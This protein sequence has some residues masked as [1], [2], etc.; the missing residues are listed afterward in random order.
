MRTSNTTLR[1]V[2]LILLACLLS[3][4]D[5]GLFGTGDGQI[6]VEADNSNIGVGN[7]VVATPTVDGSSAVTPQ[8][9]ENLQIATTITAPLINIINVSDQAV[10]ARLDTNN[11]TLLTASIAPTTFS[12]V[13]QLQLGENNLVLINPD[14]SEE[15]LNIRPLTVGASSLT[16][17]IV[18]NTPTQDLNGVLLSSMSISLTPTV[19]QLRIVQADLLSNEDTAATFSLLPS[20]NEP[21]SAEVNFPDISVA[22]ASS[23]N[24]QSIGPGGYALT[25]S[26]GRIDTEFLTLQAGKIYTLI[27]LG[28]SG[29]DQST[30]F[31]LH[32]DD[33]LNR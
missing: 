31:L 16:T 14:T 25:D 13:A 15:L 17:L 32:E 24:Y 30:S 12:Q 2:Q 23:A 18:R 6:I 27:V 21:G 11:N 10:L 19:A 22:T 8:P 26:L 9:F 5:G 7:D 1:F 4:C 29:A 33:L 28:N 20:G 3:S